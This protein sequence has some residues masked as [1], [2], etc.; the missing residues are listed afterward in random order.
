MSEQ[1][2]T[3]PTPTPEPQP[4]E[5]CQPERRTPAVV[6]RLFG[7]RRFWTAMLDVVIVMVLYFVGKYGPASLQ[8]DTQF[9]IVTLQPI[10]VMLIAAFTYED[11]TRTRVG[12]QIQ[13]SQ[14][15]AAASV[16][17][18]RNAL[19]QSQYDARRAIAE[20]EAAQATERAAVAAQAPKTAAGRR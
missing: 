1:T 13:A 16:E 6:A 2:P 14:H 5:D 9:V 15:T 4:C 3:N 10:F 8:E 11:A 12:G 7:S 19:A 20:A 17:V 18:S